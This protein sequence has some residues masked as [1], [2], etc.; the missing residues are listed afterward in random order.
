MGNGEFPSEWGGE[1]GSVHCSTVACVMCIRVRTY[2][3][4]A[5]EVRGAEE[6]G[7]LFPPGPCSSL[8]LLFPWSLQLSDRRCCFP[9]LGLLGLFLFLLFFLFYT[10][11]RALRVGVL[12]VLFYK[13]ISHSSTYYHKSSLLHIV[14][15]TVSV[16]SV[17]VYVCKEIFLFA[18]LC[19][20]VCPTLLLAWDGEYNDERDERTEEEKKALVVV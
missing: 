11:A 18:H 1:G 6:E 16:K 14:L 3:S 7:G 10:R 20:F 17:K 8:P 4:S 19:F 15:C 9:K 12:Y 2:S 13:P 5:V